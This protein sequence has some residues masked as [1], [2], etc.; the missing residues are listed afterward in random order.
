MNIAVIGFRGTGKTTI[1]RLLAK[2]LDKKLVS[3]DEEIARKTKMPIANFVKKSGWEKFRDVESEIIES[4]SELDECVFDT[5]GGI[6]VRNENVI[7][8]KKNALVILLTADAKTIA[9][10]I[11]GNKD[12]PALTKSN[13]LDEIEEVLKEREDKYRKAA[14]YAID[15]SMLSPEEVC[16]LITVYIQMELN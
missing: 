10:R 3:T 13:Y 9:E 12:R 14:D 2:N 6:V 1:C 16:G 7:N 8:L 11:R 5:G 15:T 4:V